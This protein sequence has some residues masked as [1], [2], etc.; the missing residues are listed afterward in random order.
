MTI[1]VVP[2]PGSLPAPSARL[3]V[4]EAS[5]G[6]GKTHFLEHR[7]VD[8]VLAGA[9]LRQILLVTFTDKA[10]AELRLRIRDLLDRLARTTESQVPVDS[11]TD[12]TLWHIDDAAR[13]RL[14]AAVMA[15]DH[16]PIFTIHGYCHRVLVEDAFAA[17]RLFEQTQVADEVAF[18]DAF[19]ELV[20]SRFALVAPDVD[21]LRA[22]LTRG[23]TIDHLRELLLMCA[24]KNAPPRAE[25]APLAAC[26]IGD[27]LRAAFGTS[28]KRADLVK[29]LALTGND[30]RYVPTWI[31]QIGRA[32]EQWDGSAA[33]ALALCDAIRRNGR[34]EPGPNLLSRLAKREGGSVKNVLLRALDQPSL[35][36][37]V[38][39]AMLP[40]VLARVGAVK[41]ERGMFDY[42]DMLRFVRDALHAPGGDRLARR[43]RDR[44]P[45][46]MIDE[47][48]DTDRVQWDI[49]RAIW[50]DAEAKGLTIVGDPKQAI[51]GFRGADVA[52]YCDARDELVRQGATVVQLDV[53]YRATAQMVHGVNQILVGDGISPLLDHSIRYDHPVKPSTDVTCSST[54]PP[55]A[56]FAMRG[57]GKRE[58]NRKALAAAIGAEIEALRRA[59]MP[60][61]SRGDT[62]P[63]SLSHVMVLTR[64]N[65]DSGEIASALRARGLSCT[66]VES[67]RLFETREAA[68]L[69]C[70][71]A[72]VASPRDRSARM[73]ALRSR[74]FDVA[75]GDVMQVV[76]APDHHPL[77]A[78]LL[79]WAALAN[80][81]AY[82][83]LLRSIVED[84]RFAERAIIV[85]DGERAIINTWHLIEIL[86]SEVARSRCDLHELVTKLRRWIADGS[87]RPDDRDVQRAESDANA[88]RIL[89]IHKAKGLEAPYVFVFGAASQPKFAN[90]HTVHDASGPS[91]VVGPQAERIAR[92]VQ[93]E[94]SAE[95][96][97]L[98]YVALTR[99]KVRLYLPCYTDGV[100]DAKSMYHAIER[101]LV[102][103][104]SRR[105]EYLEIVD[106]DVGHVTA[107]EVPR[108][109]LAGFEAPIAPQAFELQEISGPKAG[110]A[111]M[112][113][114]RLR[115]SMP[116]RAQT[117]PGVSL[118][119]AS[120]LALL[121]DEFDSAAQPSSLPSDELPAGADSGLLLHDLFERVDLDELRRATDATTWAQQPRTA[122]LIANCARAR[123]I[124]TAFHRHAAHIVFATLAQPLATSDRDALPPL[125]HARLLSR[126]VEF[127]YP[128]DL[129]PHAPSGAA[130]TGANAT[131]RDAP[132]NSLPR[133]MRNSGLVK[134]YIDALVAWEDDLWIV[135]YKSDVLTGDPLGA[136]TA[137]VQEHYTVQQRL[138]ALAVDRMRGTRKLAGMLFPFVR[139]GVAVAVRFDAKQLAAWATWL[140][141]LARAA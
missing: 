118:R 61:S 6:T 108:D 102:P 68:E 54:R 87:D 90:V 16:A 70:V 2:R 88:V 17:S 69:A 60:W 64:T 112:S 4:V 77:I 22:Y 79:D 12:A 66:V 63:F 82:E 86:L 33:G 3:V 135:D 45:W 109:A 9:E 55:I 101:C 115:R 92:L 96:Q 84:S 48:Q 91:L 122:A 107:P 26:E 137:H 23:N 21:L 133:D 127:A 99:A 34:S 73:R 85:G 128:I 8:L 36:A 28:D 59:P 113:Y 129:A 94:T 38:V 140:A 32:V 39:A 50:L 7:V 52:T 51:Y 5:A 43:L 111:T 71:L 46:V 124:A 15:F 58:A 110:L 31:E 104:V 97:R 56:V 11:R 13:A 114:T 20:R 132:G 98:A 134:G 138:Y 62:P 125:M 130:H 41:A 27:E 76:D 40:A 119:E 53:N 89:T 136:A 74:F 37:A 78:R 25:F 105:C 57:E 47:F 103:L 30:K 120:E 49:F 141:E 106:V 65:K 126:E 117:E 83:P 93:A 75:W 72:A 14:R 29:S 100:V 35:D 18:D 139:Y 80:R 19:I 67:D 10:V 116:L 1:A 121:E 81:R 24:R 123:G 44:T 42:D 131:A 95:N